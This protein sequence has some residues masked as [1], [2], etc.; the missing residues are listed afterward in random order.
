M[1]MRAL[2]LAGLAGLGAAL[3]VAVNGTGGDGEVWCMGK[4]ISREE[5][6]TVRA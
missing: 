2:A 6:Q 5:M 3:P 1:M 4:A